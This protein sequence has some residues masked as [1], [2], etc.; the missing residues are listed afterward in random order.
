M[1]PE[2]S[3]RSLKIQ[4][5]FGEHAPNPPSTVRGWRALCL[6]RVIDMD[7]GT[8]RFKLKLPPFGKSWI[9]P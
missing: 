7:Y 1:S 8:F 4:I 9:R 5:F 2:G 3:E 6:R